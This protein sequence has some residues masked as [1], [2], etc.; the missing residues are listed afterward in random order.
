MKTAKYLLSFFIVIL[1]SCQNNDL[2]LNFNPKVGFCLKIND[3]IVYDHS[4]IDFYD[5]SSNLV[6]LKKAHSYTYSGTGSFVVSADNTDIYSG[7]LFPAFLSSLP[8]GVTIPS[9]PT[10]YGNYIIPINFNKQIDYNG[11]EMLDPR[12]DDRIIK[13][14]KKYNQYREGLACDITDIQITAANKIQLKLQ[15]TNKDSENLY[16]LD[17]DKM[18]MNLFHYFTNGL[19]L[20]DSAYKSYTHHVT[21]KQPEPWNSWKSSWLSIIKSK[22]I[23]TLTVNYD[24]FETPTSG[25]YVAFFTFP[26][27]NHQVEKKD[28]QKTNGRI[29]LGQLNL[30][31]KIQFK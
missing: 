30:T 28:L 15:L 13:T 21:I 20:T 31:K 29:W 11:N 3:S 10:F 14:L 9:G 22:E 5:F 16:Y 12:G 8:L 27:L 17:P 7:K 23:R 25:Q 6:F 2:D 4:Q 18:G 24:N 19:I 26:G 1:L